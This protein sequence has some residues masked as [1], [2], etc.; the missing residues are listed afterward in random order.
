MATWRVNN[1]TLLGGEVCSQWQA[2]HAY[3]LGARCVCTTGYGTVAARAV[4]FECT[5]A[6]T[7]GGSQPAWDYTVGNTTSD[8]GVTWTTRSPSDGSWDNASALLYYVLNH[9]TIAAGETVLLDDGHDEGT[10]ALAVAMTIKGSTDPANPIKLICVDKADDS[11]STGAVFGIGAQRPSFTGHGYC[12]GCSCVNQYDYI[13]INAATNTHWTLD[14]GGATVIDLSRSSDVDSLVIGN[15]GN[16]EASLTIIDGNVRLETA[17][18]YIR[19]NYASYFEWLGGSV[20]APAGSVTNLFDCTSQAQAKITVRDVDLSAVG[21]GSLVKVGDRVIYDALFERCKLSAS[22]DV[23]TGTWQGV[24]MG[25]VKLHHCSAGNRSYDFY[26]ES[27]EGTVQDD[28]DIVRT[29]GASDGTTAISIKMVSSAGVS[30]NYKGLDSIPIHGWT[31]STASTTFTIEGVWDSAT[32]I[33]DDEIWMELEYPAN[34]TN[35][36]G[37]VATDKCAIL[38]T[39]ADQTTSAAT[40]A[41]TNPEGISSTVISPTNMTNDTT[42]TPYV[43]SVSGADGGAAWN[44]FDGSNTRWYKSGTSAWLKIDLGEETRCGGYAMTCSAWPNQA[45]ADWTFQGS[46]DDS[47]WTTLDT[48]NDETFS[49]SQT[50]TFTLNEHADFRYYKIDVT[51]VGGGSYVDLEGV[52]LYGSTYGPFANP[53]EFKLSVTVTPGKAGPITARVYLA[54]PSTTVYIDPMITES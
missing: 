14:G 31:D 4:V 47:A 18:M 1:S 35:G 16:E 43:A 34:N 32:N 6:G 44:L 28:T 50:R 11:L 12:Y 30:D 20:V 51:A 29:G 48:R 15:N 36:L 2:N 5:T 52:T 39:P 24:R 45:P 53:N 26:E 7:S 23:V 8:G 22:T 13:D 21:P 10:L 19:I 27:Y 49:A 33:Q 40:W 41:T 38:G 9:T 37:A 46:N 17:V 54:K 25:K 3:A 42:P